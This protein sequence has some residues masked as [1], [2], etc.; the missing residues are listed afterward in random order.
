MKDVKSLAGDIDPLKT[1]LTSLAT[2]MATGKMAKGIG[3][4]VKGA[5]QPTVDPTTLSKYGTEILSKGDW[6]EGDI[7]REL[8][9]GEGKGPSLFGTTEATPFKTLFGG[10]GDW[11]MDLI[12]EAGEGTEN[13]QALPLLLQMFSEGGGDMEFDPRSY[14]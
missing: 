8:V 1:G 14:F 13:L 11:L 12:S 10:E 4:K 6:G 2:S 3:E 5:F 9:G 7:L